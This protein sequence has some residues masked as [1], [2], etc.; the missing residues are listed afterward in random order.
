M[1]LPPPPNNPASP[2]VNTITEF[3]GPT[4]LIVTSTVGGNTSIGGSSDV[5][6]KLSKF[7]V[8]ELSFAL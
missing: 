1:I 7:I 6:T 3:S 8:I 2:L 4:K 5:F